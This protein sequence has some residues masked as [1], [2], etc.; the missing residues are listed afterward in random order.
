MPAKKPLIVEIKH[1]ASDGGPGIRTT[2]FF[3]GC[4]LSCVW[5]QNPETIDP[6]PEIIYSPEDCFGC[7]SCQESCPAGALDHNRRPY[8]INKEL[9]RRC[10]N[11]SRACPGRGLRLAG[12]YYP[13]ED[14]V[15]ELCRDIP[16][17][18]HSGGGVTLS[19]GEP[20]LHPRYLHNLLQALRFRRIHVIL[21]TAGFYYRPMFT[22]EVLPHLDLIY[23]DLK[24]FDPALHRRYTGRD[25]MRIL[26]NFR[27]LVRQAK[28]QVLPRIPLVPGITA[29]PGNL[30]ALAAFLKGLGLRCAALLPYN[31]LWKIRATGLGRPADYSYDR[32]MTREELERCAACFDGFDLES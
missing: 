21:E 12:R 31:P 28:V 13:V 6:G 17:Y 5:C 7:C 25:N 10:G 23:F 4:P 2:V 22:R 20:T 30:K 3:K 29:V 9:C 26:D 16:F 18:R 19:G 27:A 11:C 8:P 1:C 32:W 24:I 14:L 15:E